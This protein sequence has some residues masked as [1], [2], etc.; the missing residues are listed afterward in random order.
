MLDNAAAFDDAERQRIL[1]GY[2]PDVT[3]SADGGHLARAWLAAHDGTL[4]FR[5]KRPHR[6]TA[7]PPPLRPAAAMEATALGYLRARP[8]YASIYR[9]AFRNE[10]VERLVPVA[11][12]LV[13]LRWQGSILARWTGRLDTQAW[14]AHVTMAHCGPSLEERL[15]RVGTASRSHSA[16]RFGV[17]RKPV[18]G[19]RTPCAMRTQASGKF[20]TDAL[21]TQHRRAC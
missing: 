15:D 4:F 20:V 17:G 6:R 9:A 12:P 8:G 13:I 16:G 10:R 21:P 11:V 14:G 2:L 19:Q 7:S 3:P 5:G 18:P 1:S